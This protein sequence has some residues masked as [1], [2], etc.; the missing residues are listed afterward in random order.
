MYLGNFAKST[1]IWT[2]DEQNFGKATK[3]QAFSDEL[4]SKENPWLRGPKQKG[5]CCWTTLPNQ[6]GRVSN[7]SD[8]VLYL[9]KYEDGIEYWVD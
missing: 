2:N 8:I 6:H 1:L 4:E 3:F 7:G 5:M 9:I